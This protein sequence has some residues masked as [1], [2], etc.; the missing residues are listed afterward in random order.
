V[1]EG[2]LIEEKVLSLLRGVTRKNGSLD[3]STIGNSLIRVDALVGLLAV[4]EVQNKLNDTGNMNGTTSEDDLWMFD[5]LIFKSRRTFSTGSSVP[6]KRSWQSSL[7]WGRVRTN[8]MFIVRE[9]HIGRCC[10]ISLIV[11]NNFYMI[12]LPQT[13]TQLKGI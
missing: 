4:E 9:G 13:P 8:E 12:I 11:C 6:Q 10:V 5:L 1:K 3:G 2:Q 7:K